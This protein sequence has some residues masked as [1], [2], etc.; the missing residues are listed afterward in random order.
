MG[1]G[2]WWRM[3]VGSVGWWRVFRD[4]LNKG[5]NSC[6]YLRLRDVLNEIFFHF[7]TC[8]ICSTCILQ[9]VQFATR[10]ICKTCNLQHVQF[11][12]SVIGTSFEYNLVSC[13]HGIRLQEIVCCR[14]NRWLVI[15]ECES[16]KKANFRNF[17]KC[18][19]G[20]KS[21]KFLGHK[22]CIGLVGPKSR[23]FQGCK[24]CRQLRR[25]II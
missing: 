11:T 25:V 4:S 15:R 24:F 23:K 19:V 16:C 2:G 12:T 21:H 9:H 10:V 22:F 7:T 3:V 8:A 18:L 6:L 17:C 14:M 5:L 1:G 13:Q 20:P